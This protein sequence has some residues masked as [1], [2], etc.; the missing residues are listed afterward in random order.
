MRVLR[1]LPPGTHDWKKFVTPEE[2]RA[3]L[4]GAGMEIGE[5]VGVSFSPLTGKWSLS[6]D[7]SVNYMITAQKPKG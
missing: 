7:L 5:S 4:T 1:W 3:A 6:R 2:S